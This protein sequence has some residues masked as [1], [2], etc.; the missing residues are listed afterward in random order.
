MRNLRKAEAEKKNDGEEESFTIKAGD[1]VPYGHY[2]QDNDPANGTEPIQW[3]VIEADRQKD[4]AWLISCEVLDCQPYHAFNTRVDWCDSTVRAWL[5]HEFLNTAFT[6]EEQE[7][8]FVTE[9]DNSKAQANPGRQIG[10]DNTQDKVFF[11]SYTEVTQLTANV[12]TLKCFP[13]EYALAQGVRVYKGQ[14]EMEGRNACRWWLRSPGRSH[15]EAF[16]ITH[17]GILYSFPSGVQVNTTDVG[18]R[19]CIRVRLSALEQAQ[20]ETEEPAAEENIP[21][22]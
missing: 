8:I 21:A 4:S 16:F 12:L 18:V 13:T 10:S 11:L 22:E 14:Y 9:V 15:M 6:G 7:S 2:E 19:P 3:L 17:G 1:T 20:A 5:N